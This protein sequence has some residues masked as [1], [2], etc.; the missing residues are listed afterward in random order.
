MK[1]ASIHTGQLISGGGGAVGVPRFR[2]RLASASSATAAPLQ[3]RTSFEM[4][5][6][7][8]TAHPNVLKPTNWINLV[9][10]GYD[11]P[12]LPVASVP[13]VP[14]KGP[15]HYSPLIYDHPPTTQDVGSASPQQNLANSHFNRMV[16]GVMDNWI[17]Q[18]DQTGFGQLF[19][20]N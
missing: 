6:S 17:E 10:E 13:K 9:R 4:L 16:D 5:A 2:R 1:K 3:S 18:I 20:I 12:P 7:G 11:E 19:G 14:A 15:E 8:S